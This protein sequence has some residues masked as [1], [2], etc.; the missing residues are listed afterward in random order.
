MKLNYL[1]KDLT[2]VTKGVVVHGVN[3]KGV[4]GSGV[5]LALKTKWPQIFPGYKDMCNAYADKTKELVGATHF[6]TIRDKELIVGNLFTQQTFGPQPGYGEQIRYADPD[7]IERGLMMAA[8]IAV[9]NKLP[10]YTPEIGCLRGGL[11]WEADV[12][13]I[14]ERVAA[15]Y[16]DLEIFVCDI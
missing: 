11:S 9:A 6:V 5:A 4:Q 2:T 14:V 12:K 8:G 16:P 15:A 3:C 10:L 1:T 13:P 7:A